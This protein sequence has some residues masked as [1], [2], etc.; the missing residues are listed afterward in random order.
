M[1]WHPTSQEGTC[2]RTQD[3]QLGRMLLV[4]TTGFSNVEVTDVE[5]RLP[6]NQSEP[7]ILLYLYLKT[8]LLYIIYLTRSHRLEAQAN[9][10]F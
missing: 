4:V 2:F 8:K 3:D 9:G 6:N 10:Y 1:M 5:V 7:E